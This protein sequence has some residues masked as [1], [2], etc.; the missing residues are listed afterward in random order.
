MM[1]RRLLFRVSDLIFIAVFVGCL[2]IGSRMLNTDGDLGRHLALGTYMLNTR[3]VPLNDVLSF[4]RSGAPRPPYEWLAQIGLAGVNRLLGLDGVVLLTALVIAAAFL[5]VCSDALSR[6]RSPVIAVLISAWAAVA[7]SLHWLTRPHIFSFLFFALWVASLE[8]LRTKQRIPLWALPALMLVWANTHGGFVLGFLAWA[9]YVLGSW[10][11]RSRHHGTSSDGR[12]QLLLVGGAS[13]VASAITPDLWHNWE[14]VLQNRSAYVLSHTAETM[15]P[16]FSLPGTWPF[17]GMLSLGLVGIA[18]NFKI[19]IPAHVLLLVG[20]AILGAAMARNIPLFAI[21]AGPILSD[22]FGGALTSRRRWA[23]LEAA[24]WK[25]EVGLAGFVWPALVVFG[26]LAWFSYQSV[27]RHRQAYQFSPGI[28]PVKAVDW[29][30]THPVQGNLFNDFNWGGYVLYRLWPNQQV[31]IDSQS[32]FYGEALTRE[33]ED[34]MSAEGD[35]RAALERYEIRSVL[36]PPSSV[37]A[38]RLQVDAAWQPLFGDQTAVIFA[39]VS[40]P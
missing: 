13:L 5:V 25:I 8:R 14:A 30:Q 36:V 35:W 12:R 6:S 3:N 28:F 40:A 7:S 27:E 24:V 38:E 15:M 16:D 11:E 19:L 22:W 17:I 21:A 26:A 4:T 31:F 32:D 39:R 20:L 2:L 10:L 18:L 37:L 29:L 1:G 34:L 23:R 9:A 33:Y